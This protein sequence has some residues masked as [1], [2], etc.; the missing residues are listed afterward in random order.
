KLVEA[1][2]AGEQ[3]A[4]HDHVLFKEI[5]DHLPISLTVQDDDG[6]FVIVNALAAAS[7]ATPAESL[8]GASPADF[9]SEKDAASRREWELGIIR[10]GVSTTVE[11]SASDQ[12]GGRTWVASHT[13][14]KVRDR[15]LLVSTAVDITERKEAERALAERARSDELTGLPDRI[16]IEE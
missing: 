13:P 6:R 8:I 11:T 4:R 12:P 9:L 14:V 5:I 10:G 2:Q 3:Q 1:S 15:T 7:L 16:V